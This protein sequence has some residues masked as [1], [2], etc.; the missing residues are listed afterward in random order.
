MVARGNAA[1][2]RWH[3]FIADADVY[4]GDR[5]VLAGVCVAADGGAVPE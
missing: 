4:C 2:Y 3:S 5:A 1:V